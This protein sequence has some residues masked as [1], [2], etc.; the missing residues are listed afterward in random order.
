MEVFVWNLEGRG[1][2]EPA[3]VHILGTTSEVNNIRAVH[4]SVVSQ[5]TGLTQSITILQVIRDASQKKKHHTVHPEPIDGHFDLV[6]NL[7]VP[8]TQVKDSGC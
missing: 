5:N 6:E 8:S 3:Y 4:T 2:L 7:F 1:A